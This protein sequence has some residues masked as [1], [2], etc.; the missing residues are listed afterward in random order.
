M[1]V[2]NKI[3]DFLFSLDF[4]GRSLPPGIKVLNP[5]K[6]IGADEVRRICK[7]F[8]GKYFDDNNERRI[9]LGINPGRFGAG[10]T[11][12]A[13]T[14][15]KRLEDICGIETSL[16]SH[17]MSS[18]FIYEMIE[19]F[20]GVKA[21]YQKYFLSAVCP[22]GFLKVQDT[23]KEINYNYYDSKELIEA[24]DKFIPDTIKIQA[25]FNIKRDKCYC[26]GTGKNYKYLKKL[27][28][29]L[30]IFDE[31]IPLEHPRFIMQYRRK[32]MNDF[33]DKYIKAL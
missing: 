6:G 2:N 25:S 8:Y 13:F 19:K 22:L 33:I 1:K 26:L 17:E 3:I 21:F 15:T 23:G 14:D 18:E 7:E 28:K 24:T 9:I 16:N 29:K 27:N 31:I 12:I 32:K 20:G 11:G 5:Y 4:R 10:V 30:S